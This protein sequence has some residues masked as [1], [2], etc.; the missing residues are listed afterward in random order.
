MKYSHTESGHHRIES[1]IV[2]QFRA[3]EVFDSTQLQAWA[4]LQTLV[5]VE[6]TRQL[7]NQQTR[8]VRFYLSSVQADAQMFA[9]YIRSHWG[10]ENQL[11]WCL[12]VTFSEDSCRIR[13]D[14]APRNM[15]LLRRMALHLLRQEHSKASLKMKRYQ[16]A[17]DNHFLLQ[18]LL[19]SDLFCLGN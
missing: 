16:A 2:W 11:H 15:S 7:W 10:I 1:R 18:I 8:E 14:H 19:D 3:A 17:M 9:E 4:G 13:K 5:V 6:S 12:D